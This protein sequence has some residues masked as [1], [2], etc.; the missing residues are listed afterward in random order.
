M[1]TPDQPVELHVKSSTI[2]KIIV[3]LISFYLLYHFRNLILLI[4][5]S[6][7][8]ASAIEPAVTRLESYKIPRALSTILLYLSILLI[9]VA[10]VAFMVPVFV[11]ETANLANAVPG[12]LAGFEVWLNQVLSGAGFSASIESELPSPESLVGASNELRGVANIFFN[13]IA[14]ATVPATNCVSGVLITYN[15]ASASR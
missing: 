1:Q 11:T 5:T 2:V 7:V 6:I 10:L 4:L 12:Y 9:V 3:I 14:A 13:G 8:I 15:Y